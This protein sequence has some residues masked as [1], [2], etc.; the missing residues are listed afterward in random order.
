MRARFTRPQTSDPQIL[1]GIDA[2]REG[3]EYVVLEVSVRYGKSALFR[4]EFMEGEWEQSALFD[5]RAF[6]VTSHSL[7]PT[8]RYFQFDTGSVSLC[9]ESWNQPG[10]WES[11]YDHDP[12]AL[13]VY[14]TEKQ[15]ILSSS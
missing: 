14:E 4:V 8:W 5:S 11:Y 6:T 7:P 10:F 3:Q 2:L 15:E 1:Q 13:E 9:P 12:Q